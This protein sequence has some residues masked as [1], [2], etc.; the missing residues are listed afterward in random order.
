MKKIISNCK[1]GRCLKGFTSFVVSLIAV[2][3]MGVTIFGGIYFAGCFVFEK[4][5]GDIDSNIN[6]VQLEK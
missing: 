4:S 2:I 1:N 6:V 3:I 5:I